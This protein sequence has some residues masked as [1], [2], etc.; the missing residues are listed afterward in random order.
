MVERGAQAVD[1]AGRA[2][3]V[4]VAAGL[5]GAHVAGVPIAEPARVLSTALPEGGRSVGSASVGPELGSADDLGQAPVDD[6]RLAV[7]AE[8]DVAR[9][10]V[11]VQHAAAVGV[12][13]RV[14]DVEEPPQQPPQGQRPLAGVALRVPSASWNRSIASLRLSPLM[15]RMA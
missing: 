1:V 2:E 4:E 11:A 7:L 14:A 13:D 9:L 12:G 8:H 3:L 5:L 10:Q 15:N 6:Q